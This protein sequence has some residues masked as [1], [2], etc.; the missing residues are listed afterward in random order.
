MKKITALFLAAGMLFA[1]ASCGESKNETTSDT[2]DKPSTPSQE[3]TPTP[4]PTDSYTWT[5]LSAD[6]VTATD[7]VGKVKD[8]DGDGV[9]RVA[10]LGDSITAGT[11]A[12]N[13][14]KHLQSY[15]NVLGAKDGNTYEVH[16]HGKGG[17]AVRHIEEEVGDPNWGWGT[18]IDE[19]GDGKAYFYYDDKAFKT[20]YDYTPDVTIIQF[21]TNDALGGNW[22]AF[23]DYFKKDYYEYLIK[24]FEEQ[25][26]LIV[27]ATP[28]HAMN[29]MHDEHVNGPIRDAVIELAKEHNYPMVDINKFLE[30]HPEVLADGLHGNVTGYNIM[31]QGYAKYIFGAETVTATF[32]NLKEG[33][34]VRLT[35][36]KTNEAYIKAADGTTATISFV[37]GEYEFN[38]ALE[39]SGFKTVTDTITLTA[40][41][42]FSYEQK[43]GGKNVALEGKGI[44]CDSELY[45]A[46][47][48]ADTLLDG[49]RTDGGYQPKNWNEGDWCGI[50]LK[51]A[52]DVA[53]VV[54][55]WETET[56]ISS[57]QDKGFEVYF[58]VGNN[59]TKMDKANAKVSRASYDGDIVADTIELAK[60]V[61]C[62]GVKVEFLNGTISDH[63]YAPKLYEMEI[64]AE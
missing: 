2:S 6:N 55:Y 49:S 63:K 57:Y 36:K 56:Y 64:M 27:V 41:Q 23:N 61:N 37:P 26:S 44:A 43:E 46:T 4:Q 60:P 42:T 7:L 28:P 50:E 9:I 17:A 16:N 53:M 10:C 58:K 18:V 14:P 15:L 30:G 40:D 11:N 22:D 33:T 39:C 59:W 38:L 45:D 20:A 31:A 12:T 25:G 54:L 3:P 62:T 5:M 35:D 1:F 47:H 48:T 21:G 32:E 24:P 34:I 8:Q 29:G 52:E 13:W 51:N 19:D